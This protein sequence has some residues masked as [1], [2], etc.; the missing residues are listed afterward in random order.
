M[1]KEFMKKMIQAKQLEYEAFKEILPEPAAKR[2]A[3]LETELLEFGKEYF[4]TVMFDGKGANKEAKNTASDA[5]GKVRK[6]TIE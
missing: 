4:M 3:K 1:N 2:I 6:V 5:N